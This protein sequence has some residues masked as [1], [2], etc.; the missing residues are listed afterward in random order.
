M[1]T[2]FEYEE[3]I[4]GHVYDI[5]GK[6]KK[7]EDILTGLPKDLIRKE[8]PLPNVSEVNVIRHYTNISRMNFGVDIGFYPLGSCTMKYNPKIN[9]DI[10]RLD[11]FKDLHPISPESCIQGSL[12]LMWEFEQDLKKITGMDAFSLQPAAGAQGEL[13]GI[14]ITKTYYKQKNEKR[15]KIIIP[16]SAH[17]T[18]PATAAMCKFETITIPSDS[19]GNMDIYKFK[20]LLKHD[21][22][23]VMLTNPNT[24][25]LF[26]EKI[27]EISDLAHSNGSLMY[28]DGA[29]MNALLGISRPSDQGFD[30]IHLNLHKSFSTPHGGG[31]PGAGTVGVKSFLEDYLPLPRVI[32]QDNKFTLDYTKRKSVGMLRYSYGNFGMLVRA[33]SYIKS[34]GTNIRRVSE[35]AIL[36]ANYLLSLLKEDYELP[37][38]RICAHEFVLSSKKFGEKSA[39]NIAKRLMD[40]GF[41]PPTIYF[42]LIVREALMIEPT[43]TE[44][45]ETLERFALA[46]RNIAREIK[47]NPNIVKGAPYTKSIGRLDEVAAAR[48]PNLRWT[49]SSR[50]DEE[51]DRG[52]EEDDL[53]IDKSISR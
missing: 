52:G 2:I 44:S 43:E 19:R 30:M 33:Y 24:L 35:H 27:L 25:G 13:L 12:Q 5:D 7:G 42:P 10:A 23:L 48:K 21:V 32:K 31:G 49:A 9:E 51:K 4:T 38:N 45:K 50:S 14:M 47:E 26:E 11:G 34:W 3:N 1:K 40:Y 8:L 16:D 29:N 17:G 22:A 46:L 28:C 41:H 15:T 20:E 53:S 18:N 36:N 37:Y 39:L 6:E